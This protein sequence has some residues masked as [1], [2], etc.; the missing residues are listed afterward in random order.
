MCLDHGSML[1]LILDSGLKQWIVLGAEGGGD[2][3]ISSV[4]ILL[5][6]LVKPTITRLGVQADSHIFNLL[7]FVLC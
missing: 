5:S 4:L 6:V 3:N 2:V 7:M 1:I